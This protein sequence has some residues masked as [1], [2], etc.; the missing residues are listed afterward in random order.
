MIDLPS[1][2]YLIDD[3][4]VNMPS[5]GERRAILRN[6]PSNIKLYN[7]KYTLFSVRDLLLSS[8]TQFV[9][10]TGLVFKYKK[11]RFYILQS[12]I[13]KQIRSEFGI[14]FLKLK[15]YPFW[16]E[17][18]RKIHPTERFLNYVVIDNH[19]VLPLFLSR[20]EV[21]SSKVKL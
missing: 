8:Y 13:I 21:K 1:G 3:T 19:G 17:F 14:T 9:D 15:E 12:S 16:I 7:L 6:T 5:I 18:D 4:S 2:V 11:E 20:K 10:S